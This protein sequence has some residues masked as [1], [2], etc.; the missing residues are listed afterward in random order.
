MQKT[1]YLKKEEVALG[2]KKWFIFDAKDL[3][4]GRVAVEAA[5]ILRGKN[6][7]NFTPNVD[8]GDYLIITNVKDIK[9]SSNKTEKEFVIH[10]SGYIG[11]LKKMSLKDALVKKPD[12]LLYDAIKGMLPKNRLAKQMIQKLFIF[13]DDNHD[14]KAQNPIQ[15]KIPYNSKLNPNS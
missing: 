6:K 3:I 12:Q 1:T 10:H 5:N 8:C 14:K 7:P 11:G 4:L 9:Y 15:Y 2:N 13:L